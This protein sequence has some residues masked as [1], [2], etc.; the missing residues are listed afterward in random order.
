MNEQINVRRLNSYWSCVTGPI[1]FH[2]C[3]Y[4]KA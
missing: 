2:Q 3:A 4:Q 1:T